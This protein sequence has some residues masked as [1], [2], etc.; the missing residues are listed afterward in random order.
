MENAVQ[1]NIRL[2][3]SIKEKGESQLKTIG[4]TPT[5]FLRLVWEHVSRGG[6]DLA[7]IYEVIQPEARKTRLS[8]REKKLAAFSRGQDLYAEGLEQLGITGTARAN[9]ISDR[10]ILLDELEERME[11]R[12]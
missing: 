11:G 8:D 10:D 1:M 9:D 3:R 12:L 7:E 6:K 2:N 5:G 4:L